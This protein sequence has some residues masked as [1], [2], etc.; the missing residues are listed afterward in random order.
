M[1]GTSNVKLPLIG[2][3]T[4]PELELQDNGKIFFAPT[5]VGVYSKKQYQIKNL[6]KTNIRYKINIPEK[7]EGLIYFDPLEK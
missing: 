6:S 2:T 4:S 5:S 7:Y 3:C 1:P